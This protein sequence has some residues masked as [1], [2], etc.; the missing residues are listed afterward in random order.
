MGY[1]LYDGA[2]EFE[3]ED[4]TLAHMK[5]AIGMKLRRQ[6]SFFLNWT[7]DP[8]QGSGRLS[9][10]MSPTIPLIFRFSGSRPPTL[11]QKWVQVLLELANTPRGMTAIREDQVDGLIE[12]GFHSTAGHPLPHGP[13]RGAE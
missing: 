3:F 5:S 9:L 7:N 13:E 1:L 11:N 12:Q 10:W 4:R 6:E 2:N 8:D